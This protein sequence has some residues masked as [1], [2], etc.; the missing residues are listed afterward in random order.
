MEEYDPETDKWTKKAPIPTARDW[1][2]TS[3]VNGKIYAIGGWT[4]GGVIVPTVE[5]YD[6]ETDTWT[7]GVDIPERRANLSASAVNGRGFGNWYYQSSSAPHLIQEMPGD[8]AVE[9]CTSTVSDDKPQQGGLL[10]WKD[11]NNFLR[12]DRGT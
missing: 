5:I 11:K 9:V 2:A 4:P 10:I 1:F 7:K 6:P 3:V 8:F 12:F